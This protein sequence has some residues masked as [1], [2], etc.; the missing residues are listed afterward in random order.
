[1]VV[2]LHPLIAELDLN[3]V[4]VG[5]RGAVVVDALVQLA[6]SGDTSASLV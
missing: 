2:E 1:M 5:E 6:P 4:I 3:P